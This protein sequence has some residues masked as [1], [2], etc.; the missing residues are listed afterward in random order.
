[1][2]MFERAQ[3]RYEGMLAIIAEQ[4]LSLATALHDRAVQAEAAEQA[5]SLAMA[6]NR[7]TRSLR[8]TIALADRL[9]RDRRH[10]E[11]EAR[12]EADRDHDRRLDRRKAQVKAA[13][14]RL[15]RTE[16][17]EDEAEQL[18]D[19]LDDLLKAEA[20]ADDFAADPLD[21][22]IARIATDLGLP[23]PP[24]QGEGDHEQVAGGA[25]P[26]PAHPAVQPPQSLPDSSPE[27]GASDWRSS[28]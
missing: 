15:I 6:W 10:A 7:T 13:V 27:G 16:A 11:R 24:P 21:A 19:D 1:M 26:S 5:A 4:G 14:E 9:D 12:A 20:L 23:D 3:E 2:F 22:H 17:E 28:A 25:A 8:Q 18:I